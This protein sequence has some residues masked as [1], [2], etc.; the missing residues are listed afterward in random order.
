MGVKL[1]C[2]SGRLRK[3]VKWQEMLF[4]VLDFAD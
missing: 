2:M 4:A 3:K 1:G